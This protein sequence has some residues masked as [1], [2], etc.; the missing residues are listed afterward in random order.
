M[1]IIQQ[2]VEDW[3]YCPTDYQGTIELIE[4]CARLCYKSERK[5]K[6]GSA[7][8]M[9][10]RLV[11]KGHGAM[12]E[13][14]NMV[15]Q[16]SNIKNYQHLLLS[17]FMSVV[18]QKG[19]YIGGNLRAWM[20]GLRN[21]HIESFWNL[22]E[23]PP[24]NEIPYDL[25]RRVL[26]VTT[27]RAISHQLVRHRPASF[28]Q[29]SQRYDYAAQD[30]KFIEPIW[31]S[32]AGEEAQNTWLHSM[33]LEEAAYKEL[34]EL[35]LKPQEARG[36]LPNDTATEIVITTTMPHWDFILDLRSA[37]GAD[38]QMRALMKILGGLL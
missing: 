3:G 2:G 22:F 23:I 29:V 18:E 33:V 38:P 7:Q 36:V 32:S 27:S 20:E 11:N 5:I 24:L 14:S 21:T 9:V 8:K 35:G 1:Q 12:L 25:Q 17:P 13:H 31:Y 28:A 10:E 34:A 30:M 16:A 6:E 26:K 15:I 19:T 37:S 4:R